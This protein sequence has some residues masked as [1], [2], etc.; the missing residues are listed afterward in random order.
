MPVEL[1]E[2]AA[3]YKVIPGTPKWEFRDAERLTLVSAL[4]I[5]GITIEGLRFRST[6][7]VRLPQECVTFQLEYLPPRSNVKGGAF[8]RLEWRPLK[9]HNNK[10][11]GP[12][13]LQ[14]FQQQ[15]THHHLFD[16]NWRAQAK[17][18]RRGE[19]PISIPV[20]PDPASFEE[21]LALVGEKFRINNIH[22]VVPPPWEATLL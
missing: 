17:R 21:V 20:D 1:P 2:I 4:D 10:G 22:V 12:P 13:E 14:H 19:L 18:V 3:A 8:E 11:I 6:A 16:V 5:D 9:G 15:G 7:F